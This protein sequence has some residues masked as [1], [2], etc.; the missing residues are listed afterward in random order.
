MS[1]SHVARNSNG[2]LLLPNKHKQTVIIV[3]LLSKWLLGHLLIVLAEYKWLYILV[4]KFH[5][6]RFAVMSTFFILGNCLKMLLLQLKW[7]AQKFSLNKTCSKK[8]PN[9]IFLFSRCCQELKE[10]AQML[11]IPELVE[12]VDVWHRCDTRHMTDLKKAYRQVK[13]NN[14]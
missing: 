6:T 1:C 2:V 7:V 3:I 12:Y 8:I 11:K 4:I 13:R 5:T 9:Y 14:K 10:T